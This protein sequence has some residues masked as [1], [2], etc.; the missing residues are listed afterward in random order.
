MRR[1]IKFAESFVKKVKKLLKKNPHL[2]D[3]FREVLH[4]LSADVFMPSL[5]R[6]APHPTFS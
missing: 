5:L 1:K 2:E 3:V 4:K 6:Q